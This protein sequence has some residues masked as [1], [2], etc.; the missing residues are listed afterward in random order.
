MPLEQQV[1]EMHHQPQGGKND[2]QYPDDNRCRTTD[3]QE[4]S[5]ILD[6]PED[7]ARRQPEIK[8]GNDRRIA[9]ADDKRDAVN[10]EKTRRKLGRS[11]DQCCNC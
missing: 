9:N 10:E 2:H 1:A 5:Q 6:D 11:A 8:H 4:I 3:N 7:L